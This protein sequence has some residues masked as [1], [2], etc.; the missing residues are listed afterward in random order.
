[1]TPRPVELVIDALATYRITHLVTDDTVP[2]GRVRDFVTD[3]WPGSLAA[4][5]VECPWCASVTV[6]A[7]V[8]LARHLIPKWW[9]HP[10]TVLALSAV[11]GLLATWEHRD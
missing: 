11:T 10:A 6:A 5:W 1:M 2:F 3:R 9:T 4:E 7:A 8:T